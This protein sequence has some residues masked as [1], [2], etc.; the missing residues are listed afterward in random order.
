MARDKRFEEMYARAEAILEGRRNGRGLPILQHL[1]LRQYGPAMLGLA[2]R[3]TE[4][5]RRSE[6]GRI[7]DPYSPAGL[8]YRA[9]KM[10]EINAA[11]NMAM[12]LFYA[13]DMK[14]YRLW[15]HRAARGGDADAAH[16]LDLFET[17]QPYPL[18]RQIRRLRPIRRNGR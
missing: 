1:A 18:A 17:R 12:T 16:E 7:C 9:Y 10:G 13:R 15:M 14:G 2:R 8:M 4:E 5:G 3:A 11:Q 6:L